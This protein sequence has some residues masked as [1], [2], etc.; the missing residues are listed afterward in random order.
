MWWTV[1][2]YDVPCPQDPIGNPRSFISNIA[3]KRTPLI[4]QK[5]NIV[6]HILKKL[7]K[8][9]LFKGLFSFVKLL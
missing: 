9:I 4:F 3:L 5:Q 1:C 8:K 2:T 7:K 6:A